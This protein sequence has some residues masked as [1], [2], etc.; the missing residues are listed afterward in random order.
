MDNI[1]GKKRHIERNIVGTIGKKFGE[2]IRSIIATN[3]GMA[4]HPVEFNIKARA[5]FSKLG[6]DSH[7]KSGINLGLLLR[8]RL[9]NSVI[10]VREDAGL[11][12]TLG[13]EIA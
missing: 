10:T 4:F 6:P 7:N 11:S 9:G 3:S 5:C 2:L 13:S 8:T 12:E 1:V